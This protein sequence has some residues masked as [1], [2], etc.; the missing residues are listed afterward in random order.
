MPC[1]PWLLSNTM[2]RRLL[3][4]LWNTRQNQKRSLRRPLLP[5]QLLLLLCR[6]L[7][8]LLLLLLQLLLLLPLLLLPR[9]LYTTLCG[10]V[11]CT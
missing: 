3:T 1:E 11:T 10:I 5:L 6:L 2:L 7:L 9:R 4:G 8:L